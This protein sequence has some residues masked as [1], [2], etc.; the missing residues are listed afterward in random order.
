MMQTAALALIGLPA[1]AIVLGFFAGYPSRPKLTQ[2]LVLASCAGIVVCGLT[3]AWRVFE[4]EGLQVTLGDWV[5]AGGFNV[6]FGLRVDGLTAPILAMVSIVGASIHFYAA[7]Y[8][9]ED[10]DYGRFLLYFH[11]FFLSML[12]MVVSDNYLQMYMFWEAMGLASFLLIGFW[13]THDA[14][15]KA[16]LKAFLTNRVGDMGFLFAVFLM[17]A[18]FKTLRFESVFPLLAG[19]DP[20]RVSL[21][22]FAL[23]WAAAAKSAQFPLHIWLPDA[24]EGP[25]PVSAL[26]HAATMVTAGVILLARSFPFVQATPALMTTLAAV[27]A[28]TALGAAIVAGVKTDLKRILAYS[29]VSHLGLMTMALGLGSAAAA[30][31]HLVIHGFFKA[32]LFLCAGSILH[33]LG[34]KAAT[35]DDVGGLK[36]AMPFTF[37]A[38]AVGALSLSGIPPFA[39]FFSKDQILGAALANGSLAVKAAAVLISAGSAFYIFRML[40]LVFLGP[41][42][43]QTHESHPHEPGLLMKV[44]MALLA[45]FAMGAGFGTDLFTSVLAARPLAGGWGELE[46]LAMSTASIGFGAALFGAAAAYWVSLARPT[47]DWDWKARMPGLA[48]RIDSEF[49]WQPFVLNRIVHPAMS[50]AS[51]VGGTLDKRGI[52]AAVEGTAGSVRDLA[53][54]GAKL[55]TGL[56]NDYLWWMLAGTAALAWLARG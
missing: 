27:G 18:T 36:D 3:L 48:R 41:S 5:V 49:G 21:I 30:V 52:D 25:T 33:G 51:F 4:G 31:F 46:P 11:F 40:F 9:S 22:A 20:A 54:S 17:M 10:L 15:R 16:S 23:A 26:M 2:A 42:P 6:S 39:G 8:M 47:F 32:L 14:P 7:E 44:P 19:A 45:V 28:L 13:Y 1:A 38:F 37:G 53:D 50:F 12:G 24:M 55:A 34:K 43:K 29:T 56:L 35:L